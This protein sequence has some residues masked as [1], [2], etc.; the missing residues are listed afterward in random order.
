MFVVALK[1]VCSKLGETKSLL[2]IKSFIIVLHFA[3]TSAGGRKEQAQKPWLLKIHAPRN[4]KPQTL[5]PLSW[6]YEPLLL[7][8]R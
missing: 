6:K 3:H 5:N 8:D 7:P 4:C 1:V 2:P